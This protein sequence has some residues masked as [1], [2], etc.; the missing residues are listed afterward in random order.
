MEAPP[1][2]PLIV[3]VTGHR[4]LR[5]EDLETLR[6]HIDKI[7][8]QYCPAA[9]PLRVLSPL[10]DGADRLVAQVAL[11]R[12]G[13]LVVILPMDR[14]L[15]EEDFKEKRRSEDKPSLQEKSKSQEEFDELLGKADTVLTLPHFATPEE[16]KI[17]GSEARNRQYA[18][19][20]AC[21]A[22]HSHFLLALWD[23]EQKAG[24]GGTE[25]IVEFQR[26]GYFKD[27]DLQQSFERLNEPFMPGADPLTAPEPG[28]V[29]HLLTRR[30]GKAEKQ[31]DQT[32]QETEEQW[33]FEVRELAPERYKSSEAEFFQA[34][35][36]TRKRLNAF[37]NDL[38][39]RWRN[40][41]TIYKEGLC[42]QDEMTQL[43]PNLKTLCEQQAGADALALLF[44]RRTRYTVFA[45][46]VLVF[47][48][49]SGFA[50]HTTLAPEDAR[51]N[52]WSLALYLLLLALA[53]SVYLASEIRRVHSKFL[54][55]RAVAE[56]LRVQFYWSVGG[57]SKS[58]AD[59]YLRWQRSELEWIRDVLRSWRFIPAA[60]NVSNST[61][62]VQ[63]RW[64]AGQAKYFRERA[65]EKRNT[66]LMLTATRNALLL[67]SL[68]FAAFEVLHQPDGTKWLT[69]LAPAAL[70]VVLGA[71]LWLN[72]SELLVAS[73]GTFRSLALGTLGAILFAVLVGAILW[74]LRDWLVTEEQLDKE[75]LLESAPDAWRM[76]VMGL[77][78]V[79][80]AL[81]YGYAE[82]MALSDDSKQY[83][84]M[85]RIFGSALQKPS[86]PELLEALGK[87]ALAENGEWVLMH[88]EKPV[89]L[90]YA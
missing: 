71:L 11:K 49:A 13:R 43:S 45:L 46:G 41:A 25:Q 21:V 17:E 90:P 33:K 7:F 67:I 77:S 23:G 40:E 76:V 55:Y 88:R 34:V 10:A 65:P 58:A 80:G 48:A 16:I 9:T 73:Q 6:I 15:Y 19:V 27:N 31:Q 62:L 87:E 89:E 14:A 28:L 83:V 39:R 26:N 79:A 30:Q 37:N 24:A 59:H 56:G 52:P 84:R 85:E 51:K 38:T 36:E 1:L 86:G 20:G 78:A 82:V 60:S 29:V 74:W 64:I 81:V 22:R 61:Q 70:L 12:G 4:D 35:K 47:L 57:L 5:Q 68:G 8:D 53:G 75:H 50:Y 42:S 32:E 44:Q 72:R 2:A 69:I 63:E 54:D 3:G 18:L 66:L